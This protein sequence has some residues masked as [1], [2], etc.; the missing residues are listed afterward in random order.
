MPGIQALVARPMRCFY[1]ENLPEQPGATVTLSQELQHHLLRVLRLEPGAEVRLFNG[2]GGY[3]DT[4]LLTDGRVQVCRFA[5]M[6]APACRITL[7]QGLPKGDKTELILQKGTELGADNFILTPMAHCVMRLKS[8]DRQLQRWSK[9]IQEAA[10]QCRQYRLPRL[11][12]AT[13]FVDALKQGA[14]ADVKLLLWEQ[15]C[16]SF[17]PFGV[18]KAPQ[19]IAVVVGPEGGI[20][21]DELK[22]ATELGYQPVGLGPRIL[23]TET[24]GL[25]IISILQYLYG[26]MTQAAEFSTGRRDCVERT[27][28]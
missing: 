9:V 4:L 25:A 28:S 21:D 17:V 19:Q 3:A 11:Q 6:A 12:L 23:R 14:D 1:V 26:D 10:R 5:M 20:R 24:A 27:E 22:V 2:H 16:Q 13:S 7:I 15:A 8:P 18:Y